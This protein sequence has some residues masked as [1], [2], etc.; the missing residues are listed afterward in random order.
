MSL[1]DTTYFVRD[2]NVPLS[3]NATLNTNFTN[4]INRYEDEILKML[5][6]Y[7]LWKE[8][9]AGLEEESPAEKWTNLRDGAE[10]SFTFDGQTITTKWEGLANDSKISLI[11]Y[12]VYY[13]H[14]KFNDTEFTG[15][16]ERKSRSKDYIPVSPLHKLVWAYNSMVDLYGAI[17]TRVRKVSTFLNVDSYEHWNDA[18]SAYNFLL[19]NKDTY[20][21]WVFKPLA[22]QNAFGI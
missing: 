8:F 7:S 13:M 22:K 9:K 2:I 15:L 12:Y 3:A 11:A 1:I 18:P 20:T 16:A 6:G 4:S 5:L 19:A 14:R 10:F 21:G 17:P